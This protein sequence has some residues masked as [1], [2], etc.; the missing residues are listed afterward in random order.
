MKFRLKTYL[1]LFLGLFILLQILRLSNITQTY[2]N[3]R[4]ITTEIIINEHNHNCFYVARIFLDCKRFTLCKPQLVGIKV[5]NCTQYR[6]GSVL[7][8]TSS[9]DHL[10]ANKKSDLK[11]LED[12][13]FSLKSKSKLS[14]FFKLRVKILNFFRL[15]LGSPE[16]EMLFSFMFG[17][18]TYLSEEIKTQ[19]EIA[20]LNHLFAVSGLHLTILAGLVWAV[21]RRLSGLF[22]LISFIFVTLLYSLMTLGRPSIL[23]AGLMFGSLILA[24]EMFR[25]HYRSWWSLMLAFLILTTFSASIVWEI[26][27]WFS[28][29]AAFAAVLV[30]SFEKGLSSL[31]RF[32]SV[33]RWL[34]AQISREKTFLLQL[35]NYFLSGLKLSLAIN[36]ALFPLVVYFFHQYS[37]AALFTT[38]LFLWILP[39]V[40]ILGLLLLFSFPL[41]YLGF[42]GWWVLQVERVLVLPWLKLVLFGLEFLARFKFLFLKDLKITQV[43]IVFWYVILSFS[44]FILL[45]SKKGKDEV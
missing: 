31:V 10:T 29:L 12:P 34:F 15:I 26:S 4:L 38:T 27:F 32:E 5:P 9:K 18:R 28:F 42:L 39:L 40:F 8:A 24:R 17:G 43:G 35:K 21:T 36:L 22:R 19:L 6:L 14:P 2:P 20:G 41:V 33:D 16:A 11:I 45:V 7:E 25:R 30:S 3:D 1:L 13:T 44:F 23:R 37:L